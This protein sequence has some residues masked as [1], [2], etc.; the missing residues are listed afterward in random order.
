MYSGIEH[1]DGNTK[2]LTNIAS[3]HDSLTEYI[4]KE[5]KFYSKKILWLGDISLML[6]IVPI[7]NQYN[8]L[9]MIIYPMILFRNK[10]R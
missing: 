6:T 3:H 1:L 5:K 8:D 2:G 10:K 7:I 9:F 4:K